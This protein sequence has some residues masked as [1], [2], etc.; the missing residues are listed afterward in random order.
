[1]SIIVDANVLVATVL[2]SPYS[3]AAKERVAGWKRMKEALSAPTLM[4]Y[5]VNNALRRAVAAKAITEFGRER[6]DPGPSP[7]GRL[8]R[9]PDTSTPPEGAGMGR[10]VGSGEVV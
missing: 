4:E 5:E 10:P 1:M 2:P 7:T 6:C 3:S 8:F 9:G